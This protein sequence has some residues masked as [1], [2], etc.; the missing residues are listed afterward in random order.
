MS[1]E[2]ARAPGEDYEAGS[3][4]S[5]RYRATAWSNVNTGEVLPDIVTPMTWSVVGPIAA[6]LIDA[7]FGKLGIR[8]DPARLTTLIAGRAYFN[9][10]LLGSAFDL[11]PMGADSDITSIFGGAEAPPG[12]TDLPLAPEDTAQA[13][14]L[15]LA[16]GVPLVALYFVRHSPRGASRLCSRVHA[17][18]QATL[19]GIAAARDEDALE[20]V[21]DRALGM[22]DTMVD[23]IAFSGVAMALHGQLVSTCKKHFGDD[24][25]AIVNTLLAG[26][27]GVASADAGLALARLGRMGHEEPAVAE[28]LRSST[29]WAEVRMRLEEAGPDGVAFHKAWLEFLAEHGHHARGELEFGS[30]R[31]A[32]C[33]DDVLAMVV[34]LLDVPLAD[35]IVSAHA[36]RGKQAAAEEKRVLA[37]LGP[38]ARVR[39]RWL[40]RNAR[41]GARMR[42]NLK[43][44]GVR[45][46]AAGRQA[47]LALGASMAERGVFETAD[48]ILFLE[49]A[50][51]APVRAGTL[52]AGPLVASRRAD[53]DRNRTLTPPPVV[54]GE[55][56]GVAHSPDLETPF[57]PDELTGLGVAAGVARGPAR[58][59]RSLQ[60]SERVLPGEVLVAPFTDPGWTPYFIPAAAIVVDM[61]GMLSHGSIIAREY[62]IPA[63]VNV[64]PA[65]TI[66]STG[67]LVEVD[68]SHGVVR[69]LE[70]RAAGE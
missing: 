49:R 58:V 65:T 55:W 13:S 24:G 20:R 48:D 1:S 6:G 37:T 46:L 59:I 43:N 69:I 4:S 34:G 33:P 54:I 53:Y 27:G 23:A 67:D 5:P 36:A 45:V 29:T 60:S 47:L 18:A 61:G 68:G 7:L 22:L 42:E 70:R 57:E 40:L 41:A 14:R 31:W 32:E 2:V 52:D 56:D 50:E 44:E 19:D 16:L 21:A 30:P 51:V 8:F 38:L 35:D 10:S 39:F 64:G 11:M 28:A 3:P 9:A 17:E 15:R 66:I 26:Q 12:F 62:G 63:V 25:L